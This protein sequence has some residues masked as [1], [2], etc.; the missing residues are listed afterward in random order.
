M[1][2][3]EE[4]KQA[5]EAMR[6]ELDAYIEMGEFEKIYEKSKQ[7]DKLIEEYMDINTDCD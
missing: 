2:K 6:K 4:L 1:H 5:I 7:L 3:K